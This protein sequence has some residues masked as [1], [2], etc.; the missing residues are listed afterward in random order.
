MKVTLYA[1]SMVLRWVLLNGLLLL[2]LFLLFFGI[3]LDAFGKS[4]FAGLYEMFMDWYTKDS[5]GEGG[6]LPLRGGSGGILEGAGR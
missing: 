2:P 4:P 6:N 1:R 5:R 3:D